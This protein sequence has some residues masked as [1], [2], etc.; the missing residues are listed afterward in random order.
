MS[1]LLRVGVIGLGRRWQRDYRPA[2]LKLRERFEVRA[3]CDQVSSRAIREAKRLGC[4]AAAGPT[5][6]LERRDVEALLLLDSQWYGLWPLEPACRLGKP[7]FCCGSLEAEAAHADALCRKVRDSRLPV[8]VELAPR[9]QPALGRLRELLETALGPARLVI[10]CRAE[11]AP[12]PGRLGNGGIA[13]LD[14]CATLFGAEP[15]SVLETDAGSGGL[16]SLLLEFGDGRAA[17][18]T[19]YRAPGSRP[20]LR[21]RVV[22]ERGTATAELPGRVRWADAAGRHAQVLSRGRPAGESWLEQFHRAVTEKQEPRP[23][24]EDAHRLLGWLRT[25]ARSRLEGKRLA[26]NAPNK[27]S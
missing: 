14:A 25:A 12:R 16:T 26:L 2:L 15:V 7:V 6:L 3:L 23:N 10:G 13:A 17:Q 8:M 22:A 24:L 19:R 5:E 21:L 11:P 18:L 9:A 4:D 20:S 1:D 27:E